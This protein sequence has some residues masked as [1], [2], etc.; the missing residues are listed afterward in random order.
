MKMHWDY[1]NNCIPDFVFENGYSRPLQI[2]V[3][4]VAV[5]KRDHHY[6]EV[7]MS[8]A[9]TRKIEKQRERYSV[10]GNTTKIPP[11]LD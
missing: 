2:H 4:A 6:S 9:S 7:V 10:S 8:V 5:C 1:S 11:P 3:L